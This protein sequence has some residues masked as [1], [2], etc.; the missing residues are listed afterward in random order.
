[1]KFIWKI[2]L[3]TSP[4]KNNKAQKFNSLTFFARSD[5][6]IFCI[7]FA[8]LCWRDKSFGQKRYGRTKRNKNYETSS[9]KKIVWCKRKLKIQQQSSFRTFCSLMKLLLRQREPDVACS[10]VNRSSS[11]RQTHSLPKLL[12]SSIK[13]LSKCVHSHV[14]H[15]SSLLWEN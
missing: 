5:E 1:M 10:P 12:F 6:T 14:K 13:N 2:Y 4:F 8:G 11:M 3:K 9:N 7:C 15:A